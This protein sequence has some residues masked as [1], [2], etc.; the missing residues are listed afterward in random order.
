[1]AAE[2]DRL[3][4][5]DT[6]AIAHARPADLVCVDV[7][8][9][10]QV[11]IV[12]LPR[13]ASDRLVPLPEGVAP[14]GMLV[15]DAQ[16][17]E[18]DHGLQAD[19]VLFTFLAYQLDLGARGQP[20]ARGPFDAVAA[21]SHLA[22]PRVLAPRNLVQRLVDGHDRRAELGRV[23]VMVF[24]GVEVRAE[25]AEVNGSPH[26]VHARLLVEQARGTRFRLTDG[27]DAPGLVSHADHALG[28]DLGAGSIDAEV[29]LPAAELGEARVVHD[30]ARTLEHE[31]LGFLRRNRRGAEG[32][33]AL[34]PRLVGLHADADD[35]HGLHDL[36]A[37]RSHGRFGALARRAPRGVEGM[38]AAADRDA[39]VGVHHVPV[40][41]EP[42]ADLEDELP[43]LVETVEPVAIVEVP[44]ARSGLVD[45]VGCLV[46]HE[47]IEVGDH[48]WAL[49]S[50]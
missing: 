24:E 11:E 17:V 13:L 36:Q 8:V 44:I 25:V 31:V 27:A 1:M 29:A 49:Q 2:D 28:G 34:D 26:P 50:K 39:E 30:H 20:R 48:R 5:S 10:E 22:A 9:V 19:Q 12:E 38:L 14:L 41:I 15:A 33:V 40:G 47:V 4:R 35:S 21:R 42:E 43:V 16:H 37:K 46:D 32:E 45:R 3:Q 7:L 18:A 6:R 23:A